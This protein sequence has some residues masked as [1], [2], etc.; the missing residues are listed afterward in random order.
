MKKLFALIFLPLICIYGSDKHFFFS[1]EACASHLKSYSDEEKLDILKDFEIVRSICFSKVS[2]ED[3]P[4]YLATAGSPGARKSTILERFLV[5]HP[6]FNKGVYLDPDLRCLKFM[7]HTYYAR[8][9]SALESASA[10]NFLEVNKAAYEKWRGASNYITVSLLD[11]SL[12]KNLS[13]IHGTTLTG[14]H[15]LDFLKKLQREGYQITL[16]LCSCDDAV[17]TAAIEYRNEQQKF[18]Q[19]TPED[20]IAKGKFF[21]EKMSFYFIYADTLYLYW[22]DELFAPERLAGVFQKG[23]LKV[24]DPEALDRFVSKYEQDREGKNLP[25]WA[26]LVQLYHDR[27]KRNDGNNP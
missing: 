14:A 8:S 13:V 27:F 19:T 16:L 12:R 25:S 17:R 15:V 9:L 5:A 7:A 22:S 20:V 10:Q 21:P 1:P 6:E 26:D 18:F 24:Q 23:E 11:E 2:K 3:Q 4:F